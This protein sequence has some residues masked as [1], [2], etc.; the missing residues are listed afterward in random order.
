M[1]TDAFHDAPR[2]R[3]DDPA[4]LAEFLA[5]IDRAT[6]LGIDTEFVRERTFHPQPGLIQVSD[7]RR[8]WLLDPLA[9]GDHDGFRAGLADWMADPARIKILHSVGED[10]EVIDRVCGAIPDPLFDTQVAAALI[11]KPLQL[12]YETL[13]EEL[14]GVV[15]PGGLARNNWL[16][17]PLPDAWLDYAAH[18]VIA[19]P[20]L[21]AELTERLVAADRLAWHAE[22]CARRVAQARTPVDP[23]LRIRG[24]ERLDDEALARLVTLAHW[25]D[26]QARERDLPR[27]FIAADP[28]LLE[29]ARRNPATADEL[30]GIDALKPGAARRFGDELV[31]CCGRPADDWTRPAAL[32]P[33]DREGRDEVKRL[34]GVV[35]ERAEALG[36]DPALLASKRE[37]ERIVRGERP[38]WLDGW[39]GEQLGELTG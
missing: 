30:R 16:R 12:K 17:R 27:T 14:L 37:L 25:R 34:Q 4:G 6:E 18:D 39:R 20:A 11:G 15:F 38:E 35:R 13:A 10:F 26:R 3:V 29:I 21:K 36:V 2:Q 32:L 19:L 31:A 33:L 28:A 5:A 24:A 9:L 22:D 23:V 1:T 8:V 7:G